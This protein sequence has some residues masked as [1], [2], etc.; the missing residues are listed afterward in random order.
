MKVTS[1]YDAARLHGGQ[2][3][4]RLLPGE[5]F[6][7]N[8][9]LANYSLAAVVD[10]FWPAADGWQVV[11]MEPAFY[12]PLWVL[13]HPTRGVAVALIGATEPSGGLGT[14]QTWDDLNVFWRARN[15][16][17]SITTQG[18]TRLAIL[19]EMA[20]RVTSHGLTSSEEHLVAALLDS[21]TFDTPDVA[22]LRGLGAF[23]DLNER[24]QDV[25]QRIGWAVEKAEWVAAKK[26]LVTE[27]LAANGTTTKQVSP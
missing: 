18:P 17:C 19:Q 2:V 27:A 23:D 12:W 20:A 8:T 26:A 10:A 24:V 6:E 22:M 13:E 21:P 16:H 7:D 11:A 4:E 9:H 5:R 15:I 25:R 14:P 1:S 3:C